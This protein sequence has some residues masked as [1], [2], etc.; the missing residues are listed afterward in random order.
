MNRYKYIDENKEHMHTLDGKPL[1]GTSSVTKIIAKPLMWWASG[2]AVKELGWT[3][4]KNWIQ[5]KPFSTPKEDRL[6]NAEEYLAEIAVM[7]TDEYLAL[8]DRAYKAHDEKKKDAAVGGTDRHA[9]L[10]T[11]VKYCI[12]ENNGVPVKH[13]VP[14]SIESFVDWSLINIKQFVW[15][16]ANCYSEVLWTG[17]IADVGWIDNQDRLIAGDFKSS[18]EAYFD[19]FIQIAGYDIALTEN[20]GYDKDGNQKFILPKPIQGYCV[21]PFGAPTLTPNFQ[22]DVA[23]YR[24]GYQAALTLTKLQTTYNN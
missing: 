19:Q 3:P 17:G 12:T 1:F 24:K 8:L 6:K 15:S 9:L 11:W 21:I 13:L 14:T 7:D 18:K 20:G 22:W 5:G 4:I 16:E 23:A 2:M 10:E